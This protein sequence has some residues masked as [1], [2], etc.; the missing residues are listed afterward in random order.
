MT[1]G[2][3]APR[4]S[5]NSLRPPPMSIWLAK[6]PVPAL[7]RGEPGAAGMQAETT[8]SPT[9]AATMPRRPLRIARPLDATRAP[10]CAGSRRLSIWGT[11]G[12]SSARARLP[13]TLHPSRSYHE[14]F[15]QWEA[16]LKR[17][18]P[19]IGDL[20]AVDRPSAGFPDR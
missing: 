11:S 5:R 3:P 14:S 18:L 10:Y 9:E 7:G 6:S 4:H 16:G 2:P 15:H 13:L 12:L 1:V 17:S 20:L 19:A 8:A